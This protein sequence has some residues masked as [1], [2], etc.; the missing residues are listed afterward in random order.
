MFRHTLR[1]QFSTPSRKKR[2]GITYFI[3]TGVA[4]TDWHIGDLSG[5]AAVV[6][7]M[8]IEESPEEGKRKLITELEGNSSVNYVEYYQFSLKEMQKTFMKETML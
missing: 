6:Q 5:P 7:K 4:V 8:S 1:L 2:H 3:F